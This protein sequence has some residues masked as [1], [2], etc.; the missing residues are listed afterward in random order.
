MQG[1]LKLEGY[2]VKWIQFG[3]CYGGTNNPV[4]R[5]IIYMGNR[6]S[7]SWSDEPERHGECLSE[8]HWGGQGSQHGFQRQGGTW[9]QP[10]RG[11]WSPQMGGLEWG[12][13][14]EGS[15]E[16]VPEQMAY[17]RN[18][19]CSLGCGGCGCSGAGVGGHKRWGWTDGLGECGLCSE[20][21]FI[22]NV[23]PIAGF[24]VGRV[25]V[26]FPIFWMLFLI[27]GFG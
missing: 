26:K 24:A 11:Q 9:A 19:D 2:F 23:I 18:N 13:S 16:S 27:A 7:Q 15:S 17:P 21:T 1:M 3:L 6:R 25:M 4:E 12:G 5:T 22:L 14:Q 8:D 10:W 20:C